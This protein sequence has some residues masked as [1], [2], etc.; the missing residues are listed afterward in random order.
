LIGKYQGHRSIPLLVPRNA[1]DPV[2]YSN[3]AGNR[4]ILRITV[5]SSS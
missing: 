4:P 5:G 1:S 2:V 3:A